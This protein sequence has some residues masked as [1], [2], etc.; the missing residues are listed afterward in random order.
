[1]VHAINHDVRASLRLTEGERWT[2][3]AL[4]GLR[5]DEYRPAAW[6]RFVRISLERSRATRRARPALARQAR[7]WGTSGALAW[8]IA[9]R[10]ARRAG[11]GVR[12]RPV[13]GL[14]WW[15]AVWQM[16]DW[17]LGMVEGRDGRSHARL[18]PADGL[19]LVRFW[20]VPVVPAVAR[21]PAGLPAV[22]AA[23]GV[24]DWLDGALARRHGP[25][26]LGEDLDTTADLAF[27]AMVA[28]SARAA[29]RIPPLAFW[30]LGARQA[31]GLALSLG[32]F[33]GRARRP[34]ISAR[35]WG[36]V[37]RVAGLAICAA[38]RP[39]PGTALLVIG[40]LVPPQQ[41]S[42]AAFQSR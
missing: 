20:L 37:P 10:A 21:S 36:A 13:A 1:M 15:L 26:R 16:L 29:D 11:G 8:V 6:L 23:G 18:A 38:G 7:A 41:L 24:T 40:C 14:C 33:F 25:T 32:T 5:R 39:R 31:L 42:R 12:L 3:Q 4:R 30:A 9:A 22:I 28:L 19:S 17:H 34:A 27:F 35:R 2:A